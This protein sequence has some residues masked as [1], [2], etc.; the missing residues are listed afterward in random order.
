MQVLEGAL[1]LGLAP[2]DF[3]VP[4]RVEG[5]INVDEV[6]AGSG[7]LLELFQM[8]AA[9]DEAGVHKGRRFAR[10]GHIALM[11]TVWPMLASRHGF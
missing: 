7:Q 1:L 10:C 4:V 9:I 5:R 3:V 8:I 11:V 2:K 6:N